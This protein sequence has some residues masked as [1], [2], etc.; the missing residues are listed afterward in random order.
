MAFTER[1]L[2]GTIHFASKSHQLHK[3]YTKSDDC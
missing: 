2:C 1:N 3:Y